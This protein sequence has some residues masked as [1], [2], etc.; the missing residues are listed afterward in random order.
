[1][2]PLLNIAIRAV[3]SAGNVI[4]RSIKHV[5]Y[6]NITIKGYNNFISDMNYLVEREIIGVIAKA[7]PEHAIMAKESGNY[8]ESNTVWIVDPLDGAINFV[9]GLPHY[10]VSIAVM[11]HNKIEHGV[12]YDPLREELFTASR[13]DGARLNN[14]RLR[15]NKRKNLINALLATGFSCKNL[16]YLA[17]FSEVMNNF[18][19]QAADVR[20]TGSV[21]LDLAYVATGRLDGYWEIDVAKWNLAAGVLMI[22]ES[23]GVISDFIGGDNYINSGNVVVGNVHVQRYILNEIKPY[24]MEELKK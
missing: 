3:R 20:H 23:G 22:E 7:Y 19:I 2:H 5:E 8:G 10:C 17:A 9:H 16:Q 21:A 18:L 6:S 4:I 11:I 24:L 13:G 15:V 1:M 14:R 12:I